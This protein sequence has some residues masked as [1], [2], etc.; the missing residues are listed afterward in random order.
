MGMSMASIAL[1]R[2]TKFLCTR[3]TSSNTKP[4]VQISGALTLPPRIISNTLAQTPT[5]LDMKH[6]YQ[7]DAID[8]LPS[9]IMLLAVDHNLD[10]NYQNH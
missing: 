3:T 6:L 9:G 5:K 2:M 7:I 1:Q 4:L 10:H 8:G